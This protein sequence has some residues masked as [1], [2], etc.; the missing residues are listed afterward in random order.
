MDQVS[1]T[2]FDS[3]DWVYASYDVCKRERISPNTLAYNE[4][5][6]TLAVIVKRSSGGDF[7]L[8]SGALNYLLKGLDHGARRDGSP[9]RAAIVVLADVDF[10]NH[11]KLVKQWSAEELRD[12]FSGV[13]PQPGKFGPY[14]WSKASDCDDE[15]WL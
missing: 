2:T 11:F 6:A 14:W 4:S 12:R 15:A 5:S 9:V 10:Q 8:S 3:T 7:A 1:Q 13:D